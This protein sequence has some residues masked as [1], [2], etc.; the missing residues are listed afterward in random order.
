MIAVAGVAVLAMSMAGTGAAAGG[1]RLDGTFE[2]VA[3]FKDND[4][5]VAPGTKT[6]QTFKFKATCPSGSCKK[7]KLTRTDDGGSY[8]TTLKRTASGDYTGVEGPY[9]YPSCLDNGAATFTSDH[10][11]KITATDNGDATKIGGTAHVQIANC[12]SY[13]FVNYKIAGTLK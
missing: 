5:G 6:D 4:F 10:K 1:A 2:V 3:T 9:P 11:I 8:K 13:S 7:V 12:D